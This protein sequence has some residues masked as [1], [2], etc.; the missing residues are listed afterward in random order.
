METMTRIHVGATVEPREL[1]TIRG[2]TIRIP[3]PGRLV[4]LQF[5]RFAG[6][7]VCD[8][9][10]AAISRRWEE[11]RAASIDEVVVFHSSAK[12]L[13]PYADAL[14]FTII[15]DPGKR[16]YR[17]F[18]VE[19]GPRALLDPRAWIPV[20]R[21][22]FRSGCAAL[23]RRKPLP[24]LDAE[25]GRL[26]LPA[27]FLI[28]ADGQVVACKYGAHVYDQWSVDEILALAKEKNRPRAANGS[29]RNVTDL[30]RLGIG[31]SPRELNRLA[32]SAFGV[33]LL[34]SVHHAYG[35]YVY[36]TPWRLHVVIVSVLIAAAIA[37]CLRVLRQKMGTRT[38]AVGLFTAIIFL[39]PVLA[40]GLFEGGYNH[41]LKDALYFGGASQGLLQRLFP[42]PTYEMPNDAFF[43]VT[44]AVQL[45]AGIVTWR[46]LYHFMKVHPK[47]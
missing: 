19:A 33:L 30:E 26:G 37:A 20:L 34:T 45:I 29:P 36:G 28:P 11:V 24:P 40:I 41:A 8:L 46:H 23:L 22:L 25:G 17:E 21:S 18:S 42:A 6:C 35:A 4:H 12:T 1:V 16:L 15:A 39:F 14:P 5:R 38:L 3:T 13:L 7:P 27:D 47:P 10:L 44:G 32:S 2:E 43:E 9:H 31:F